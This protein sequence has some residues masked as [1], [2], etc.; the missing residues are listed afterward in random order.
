VCD[1]ALAAGGREPP[2]LVEQGP[3]DR[4]ELRDERS[5]CRLV[6]PIPEGEHMLLAG[7]GQRGDKGGRGRHPR[8]QRM[9]KR[10]SS[11]NAMKI[12]P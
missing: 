6:E 4:L 10:Q 12:T 5:L 1:C 11:G 3:I 2:H 8:T 7:A 9:K